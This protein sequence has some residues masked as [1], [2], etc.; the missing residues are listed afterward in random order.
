MFYQK[1]LLL[2][3][4]LYLL[5]NAHKYEAVATLMV[6]FSAIWDEGTMEYKEQFFVLCLSQSNRV[7]GYFL[8]SSGG[9]SGTVVDTKQILAVAI[10]ANAAS[11]ILC[12]NHP[13]GNSNPSTTDRDL[14]RKVIRAATLLD[15]GVLVSFGDYG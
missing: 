5:Q 8:H 14:T 1:S 9:L 13:S 2:F 10:K 12:H 15:V 6:S 4:T 3:L 11:I 7:L